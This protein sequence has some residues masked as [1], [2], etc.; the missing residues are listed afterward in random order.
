M[1]ETTMLYAVGAVIVANL[2]SIGAILYAS[3]RGV[4]FLSKLDSKV[5]QN[6]KDINNAFV[7]IRDVEIHL[8]DQ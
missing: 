5:D 2:G 3:A 8:R 1:N 4:W 6:T 7:K